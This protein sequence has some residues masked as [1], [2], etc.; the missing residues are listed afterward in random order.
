MPSTG[1]AVCAAAKPQTHVSINA[2]KRFTNISILPLLPRRIADAIRRRREPA[3]TRYCADSRTIKYRFARMSQPGD[4]A[5]REGR[6]EA[7]QLRAV[8]SGDARIGP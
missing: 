7:V 3:R 2:M 8:A 1:G 4:V 5:V 6:M